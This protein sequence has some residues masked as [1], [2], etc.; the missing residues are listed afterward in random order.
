MSATEVIDE[1]VKHGAVAD[2]TWHGEKLEMKTNEERAEEAW[3]SQAAAEGFDEHGDDPFQTQSEPSRFEIE[4]DGAKAT[5]KESPI[6]DPLQRHRA[7]G[8][9]VF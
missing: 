4:N 3:A 6:L 8:K 1:L 5:K 2:A 7:S 9:A